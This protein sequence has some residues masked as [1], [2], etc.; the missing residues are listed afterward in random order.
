MKLVGWCHFTLIQ[1]KGIINLVVGPKG[2]EVLND[3]FWVLTAVL[4]FHNTGKMS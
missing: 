4:L 1:Y 2:R 3:S